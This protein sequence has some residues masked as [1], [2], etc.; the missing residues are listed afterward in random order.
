MNLLL[1]KPDEWLNPIPRNDARVVHIKKI[2]KLSEGD[3]LE[4]GIL[5]GALGTALLEEI[6]EDGSMRFSFRS[7]TEPAPLYPL[8]LIVGTPPPPYGPAAF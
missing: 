8:T 5:G 1:F 6:L 2:L 3:R 7:E 4:A